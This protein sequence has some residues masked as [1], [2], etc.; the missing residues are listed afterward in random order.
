MAPAVPVVAPPDNAVMVATPFAP[1]A[2][3][4]AMTRPLTSV[5]ASD[6]STRPSVVD[7]AM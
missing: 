1:P 4:V 7:R 5:V 2:M 6:G 3:N